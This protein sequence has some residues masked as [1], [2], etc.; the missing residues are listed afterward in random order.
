MSEHLGYYNTIREEVRTN[1]RRIEQRQ[2]EADEQWARAQLPC[3]SATIMFFLIFILVL[4]VYMINY[5]I[6]H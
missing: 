3:V 4:S 2:R 5:L 6:N 1:I